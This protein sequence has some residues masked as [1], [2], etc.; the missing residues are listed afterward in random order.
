MITPYFTRRI[1]FVK[2]IHEVNAIF[3]NNSTKSGWKEISAPK[4]ASIF[5]NEK[6]SLLIDSLESGGTINSSNYF[7]LSDQLK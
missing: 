1:T 5:W 3:F 6:G 2:A 4:Q 7:N